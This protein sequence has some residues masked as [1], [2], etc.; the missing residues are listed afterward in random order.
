[1]TCFE[2]LPLGWSQALERVHVL[3]NRIFLS[4]MTHAQ[5]EQPSR[6]RP[7]GAALPRHVS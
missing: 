2:N 4:N 1:M 3:I 7:G 5:P 6:D